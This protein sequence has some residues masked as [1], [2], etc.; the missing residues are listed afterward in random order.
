MR[1]LG[2]GSVR[3]YDGVDECPHAA[4]GRHEQWQESVVLYMW[5]IEQ[6]VYVYLRLSQEPNLGNGF[7]T[8]W[9]NAWTPE[10]AYKHTD[11]SIPLNAGDVGKTSLAAGNGLCRYTY[12]GNHN[13]LVNDRDAQLALCMKD[14]QAGFGY[15]SA[16]SGAIVTELANNHIEATGWVTGTVTVRGKTY[17]VAG[18]G[19]RDHSWGRRNW[20]GILAHRFYPA[21]F[22]KDFN[23]FCVTFVGADGRMAK[24]GLVIRNDT[25]FSTDD[26]DVVAYMAEDGVS[27]CGGRVTLRLDGQILVL[28]YE[29]LAKCAIS[30]HHDLACVDGMCKVTMGGRV[31]V[32]VSETSHRAQ[33][34]TNR[35]FVFSHSPGILDNGIYPA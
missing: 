35:P 16:A 13:W 3:I 10:C 9:I 34:G 27:N 15:F 4:E 5:D 33:G 11:D 7:T 23:F 24:H 25:V 31:G 29:L 19:W 2:N 30:L 20:H 8:A 21:M 14:D 6:K 17:R 12:D 32:G 22:G 18:T 1:V 28:E 26:F